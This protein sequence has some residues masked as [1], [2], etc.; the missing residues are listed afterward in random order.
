[1]ISTLATVAR[2]PHVELKD[3]LLLIQVIMTFLTAV[4]LAVYSS[5]TARST[6]ELKARLAQEV[7]GSIEELKADLG[8]I[9]PK[10]HEA[11][12]AMWDAATKYLRALQQFELGKFGELVP[13]P[14]WDS[15]YNSIT[16]YCTFIITY[17]DNVITIIHLIFFHDF[18]QDLAILVL[19]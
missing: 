9:V 1:M 10:T 7:G 2:I 6:E 16:L 4:A 13:A 12:H 5:A 14:P 19:Y 18:S 11:Y 3:Y 15:N 8:Q 17:L